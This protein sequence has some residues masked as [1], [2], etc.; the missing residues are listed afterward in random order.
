MSVSVTWIIAHTDALTRC[1]SGIWSTL[2]SLS[3]WVL[4]FRFEFH[5]VMKHFCSMHYNW[6]L[7][8]LC[9]DQYSI[10]SQQKNPI[11]LQTGIIFRINRTK[12]F[13]LYKFPFVSAIIV[14]IKF[15]LWFI[16]RK[17]KYRN[18]FHQKAPFIQLDNSDLTY[19]LQF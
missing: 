14:L 9:F 15:L 2:R 7:L 6:E 3:L 11:W 10:F 4:Y 1:L 8:Y 17:I 19:Q 5:S 12:W 13:D 18:K 16:C